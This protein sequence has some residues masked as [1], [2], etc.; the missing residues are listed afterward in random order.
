M[1]KNLL[2]TIASLSLI[3]CGGGG[4]TVD[5]LPFKAGEKDNWGMVSPSGEILFAGEFTNEPSVVIGGVFRVQNA[6]G[7]YELFKAN[8][9][10]TQIGSVSYLHVGMFT[11]S[12]TPAVLPN[13]PVMLIDRG[14]EMVAKIDKLNGKTVE[15]VSSF[16]D[17]YAVYTTSEPKSGMID[18]KGNV[19]IDAKYDFLSPYVDDM[20]LG[21]M[22]GDNGGDVYIIDKSGN[23]TIIKD[24]KGLSL[25]FYSDG[26]ALFEGEN[27]YIGYNVKGEQ[28]LKLDD[29][30]KRIKEF[31]NG[32][33]FFSDGDAW[34]LINSKGEIVIR[35]KYKRGNSIDK[36]FVT[37]TTND[38]KVV[39][40]DFDGTEK[41]VTNFEVISAFFNG[42]NAFAREGKYW[43]VID[44]NGKEVESTTFYNIGKDG[45]D[46]YVYF[47]SDYINLNEIIANALGTISVDGMA[48]YT[49]GASSQSIVSEIMPN[50]DL[51]KLKSGNDWSIEN[52]DRFIGGPIEI[53]KNVGCNVLLQFDKTPFSAIIERT[54]GWFSYDKTVGYKVNDNATLNRILVALN[55]SARHTNKVEDIAKAAVEY[56]KATNL[57]A[58]PEFSQTD[59]N[60]YIFIDKNNAN[61]QLHVSYDGDRVAICYEIIQ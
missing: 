1:K 19:F 4:S 55:V 34:G 41:V 39:I 30:I 58:E 61:R 47:N 22:R 18:T 6:D 28:V 48:G 8:D 13:E 24:T 37:F 15:A 14:G 7:K 12:V 57:F 17:G 44:D 16:S 21:L 27:N 20:A 46:E 52:R 60:R 32:Y 9:K 2:L 51:N 43:I 25:K 56:I 11:E 38:G 49:F 45:L 31:I 5:Y 23:G 33:A 26:I 42:K 10:P 54:K 40:C 29:K 3:S 53:S 35:A 50:V 36:N 59:E